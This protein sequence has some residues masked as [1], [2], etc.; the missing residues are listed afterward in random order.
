MTRTITTLL[1]SGL[2]LS[3]A[4]L[5]NN[6]VIEQR[7]DLMERTG[8]AAKV[9]GDMLKEE[10]P[11]DAAAAMAALEVLDETAAQAGDLFP[12]GSETGNDTEARSTIWSDPEGFEQALLDFGTA[13]DNAIAANPA[14]LADLGDA[15]TPVFK[16]CKGC[17]EDYRVEKDD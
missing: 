3:T 2:L 5:A 8:D 17:H 16:T 9:I 15:A 7:Q 1:V 10:A 13:V 14:S 12:V 6:N 11:F 4:V